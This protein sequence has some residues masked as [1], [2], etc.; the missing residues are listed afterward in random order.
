MRASVRTS[1]T[2]SSCSM[3]ASD[4]MSDALIIRGASGRKGWQWVCCVGSSGRGPGSSPEWVGEVKRRQ[5][6]VAWGVGRG[7]RR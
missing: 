3:P 5:Y 2:A 4:G 7:V 1:S 6:I